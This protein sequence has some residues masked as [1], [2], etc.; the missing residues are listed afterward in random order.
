MVLDGETGFLVDE[1]NLVDVADKVITIFSND[2]VVDK[3]SKCAYEIARKHSWQA[4][5]NSIST[6]AE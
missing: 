1:N 5:L 3:M 6:L 4:Y 2:E